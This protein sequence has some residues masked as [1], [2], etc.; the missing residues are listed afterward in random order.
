MRDGDFRI[1]GRE[2]SRVDGL[3]DAVFGFAIALL[4]FVYPLEFIMATMSEKRLGVAG[5]PYPNF[6]RANVLPDRD[7]PQLFGAFGLGFAG[8]FAVFN[9]MY[10]HAYSQPEHA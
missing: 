8:V 2:I 7:I 10:R 9:A 6:H 4:I 5:F 1:R 3:S